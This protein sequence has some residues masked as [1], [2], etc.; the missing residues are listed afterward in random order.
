M[1]EVDTKYKRKN[2]LSVPSKQGLHGWTAGMI[3]AIQ[4]ESDYQKIVNKCLSY[5]FSGTDDENV[6]VE[7]PTPPTGQEDEQSTHLYVVI[8]MYFVLN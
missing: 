4:G 2:S 8:G 3:L 7:I 5:F 6:T 1:P